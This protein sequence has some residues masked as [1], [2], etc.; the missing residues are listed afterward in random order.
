MIGAVIEDSEEAVKAALDFY[1]QRLKPVLEPDRIGEE[2]AVYL[3]NGDWEVADTV[4]EA[5][6]RLRERHPDAEFVF[7]TVGQPI[8]PWPWLRHDVPLGKG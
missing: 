8:K 4:I 1:E 7:M 3:P 6:A 5:D 2:V